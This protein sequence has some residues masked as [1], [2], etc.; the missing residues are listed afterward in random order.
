MKKMIKIKEYKYTLDDLDD[1]T[2][3]SVFDT[4][5]DAF[6]KLKNEDDLTFT[7]VYV[8]PY[9]SPLYDAD[10]AVPIDSGVVDQ[11]DSTKYKL[12]MYIKLKIVKI[13]D[14]RSATRQFFILI[15]LL[16]LLKYKGFASLINSDI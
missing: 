14:I 2:I 5:N 11:E 8:Q 4:L 15:F 10:V 3:N 13:K 6:H 9:T 12:S 7:P 16:F 1:Y